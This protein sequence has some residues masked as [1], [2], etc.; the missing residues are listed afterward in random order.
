MREREKERTERKET[1]TRNTDK[2]NFV[3]I[4]HFRLLFMSCYFV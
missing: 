4:V 2:E 3:H 1:Q